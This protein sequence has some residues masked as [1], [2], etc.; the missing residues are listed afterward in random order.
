MPNASSS[1]GRTDYRRPRRTLS[2]WGRCKIAAATL[3]A[4]AVFLATSLLLVVIG[5]LTLFR[6][7]RLY[8]EVI[9]RRASQICLA[10]YGVRVAEIDRPLF[11]NK[12]TVFISNHTSL[13]DMFVIMA[14]GLPNS[15]YFLSGFLRKYP[16]LWIV[17]WMIGVFWTAPQQYPQR[18]TEIFQ[19]AT[20]KLLSTGESVFLT[21]EGQQTWVFN[22]GAFHLAIELQAPIRP[23]YISIPN[24]T[25]PGPWIGGEGFSIRP[26][27]IRVFFRDEIDTSQ[28]TLDQV[29]QRRDETRDMYLAWQE[30]I[31]GEK[32]DLP[33]H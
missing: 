29:S 21:P 11:D 2:A 14:L 8:A 33:S 30:E 19:A 1:Q 10:L 16:P 23:F 3:L 4:A 28:W 22:R 13:L 27:V 25:D 20:Q 5:L 31:T 7:R 32:P 15:R 12:Q 18:R 17:G 9:T 24:D 6:T 26:G